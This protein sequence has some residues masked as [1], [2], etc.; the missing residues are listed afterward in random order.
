MLA[1]AHA[2]AQTSA[3][4][5]AGTAPAAT[6][7]AAASAPASTPPVV[8]PP[9]ATPPVA[10]SPVAGPPVATPSALSTPAPAASAPAVPAPA[11]PVPVV[12]PNAA[13]FDLKR[14]E[15]ATFVDEVVH[16]DGLSRRQVKRLLKRAQPQPKIIE[17]MTRP[18]EKISPWWEYREH[19]LSEERINDGVQ[20]WNEHQDALERV[21]ADYHVPPEY[22]VSILGVETK[23]G[24]NTGG[25]RALD[26][27][28]TLAFDYPPRQKFFR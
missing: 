8:T 28:A 20:F 19:F 12:P 17:I 9:V 1:S 18:L 6:A 5:P 27:L 3:T 14:P 25:Y 24:R 4:A 26:A 7:P 16:R 23:Y 22:L 2:L 11:V 10:P 21:A 15:I 13:P